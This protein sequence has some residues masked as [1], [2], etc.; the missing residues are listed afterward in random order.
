ML[1]PIRHILTNF[2]NRTVLGVRGCPTRRLCVWAFFVFSAF[3][4]F[5]APQLNNPRE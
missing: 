3:S 5:S 2:R 1:C 4:A